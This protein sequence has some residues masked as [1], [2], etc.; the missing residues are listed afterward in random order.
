MDKLDAIISNIMN[1]VSEAAVGLQGLI[2]KLFEGK[3]LAA[4]WQILI[5]F[6]HMAVGVLEFLLKVLKIFVK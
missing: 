3:M 5:A 2:D 6:C 4:L 1:V